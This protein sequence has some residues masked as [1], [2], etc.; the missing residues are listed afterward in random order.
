[1][2]KVITR[3]TDCNNT[4]QLYET[5]NASDNIKEMWVCMGCKNIWE[6]R[7]VFKFDSMVQ[8]ID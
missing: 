3:C 7:F 2:T 1:M 6:K 8:L 5:Q 4:L